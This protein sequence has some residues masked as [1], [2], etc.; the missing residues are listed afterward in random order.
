MRVL[1]G[2]DAAGA[3]GTAAAPAHTADAQP[4]AADCRVWLFRAAAPATSNTATD[5]GPG[6]VPR[7]P[8]R[9]WP[10]ALRQ[11]FAQ[12]CVARHLGV[13]RGQVRIGHTH[14]GQP[15]VELPAHVGKRVAISLSDSGHTLAVAVL[16]T[17][18]PAPHGA[19]PW[20]RLGI[21]IEPI[22]GRAVATGTL[23]WLAPAESAAIAA[24]PAHARREHFVAIWTQKE[25]CLKALGLGLDAGLAGFEVQTDPQSPAALRTPRR[26]WPALHVQR[27]HSTGLAGALACDPHPFPLRLRLTQHTVSFSNRSAI[28]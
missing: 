20:P 26:D 9:V 15:V 1:P 18:E 19:A 8:T 25:A 28:S 23:P 3:A 6:A 27:L 16:A 21:D 12:A 4:G 2:F 7:K 14:A 22:A 13:P 17:A 10:R 24:A 11:R 5:A